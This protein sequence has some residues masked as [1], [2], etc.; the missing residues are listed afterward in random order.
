MD[1][2]TLEWATAVADVT[3]AVRAAADAGTGCTL[4]ATQT[5]TLRQVL[6]VLSRPVLRAA[7][8]GE[9]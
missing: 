7:S 5:A 1:E 6:R 2:T 3:L 4:T 8:E 9:R